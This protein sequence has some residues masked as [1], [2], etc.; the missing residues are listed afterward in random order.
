[1]APR[2][3]N[4]FGSTDPTTPLVLGCA[5]VGALAMAL[6]VGA[7]LLLAR[8]TSPTGVAAPPVPMPMPMP[9]PAPAT[10]LAPESPPAP[11]PPAPLADPPPPIEGAIPREAIRAA[12][13]RHLSEVRRCYEDALAR[14]PT[15]EARVVAHFVV[16]TDGSVRSASVD[17][18]DDV[19]LTTC[20]A[21]RVRTWAFPAP[22]GG[23][24]VTVHYPFV[25]SP[26]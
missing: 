26:E 4:G 15:L 2:G 13:Q 17:G 21:S 5:A 1:M 10:A 25:L 7:Y 18:A 16:G 11:A 3:E 9:L 23:A 14:D 8:P 12:V 24:L 6:G 19:V 20:I 22:E